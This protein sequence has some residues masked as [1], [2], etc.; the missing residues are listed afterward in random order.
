[1][2]AIEDGSASISPKANSGD[3]DVPVACM[4]RMPRKLPLIVDT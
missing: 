2:K 3:P 4:F 1:M